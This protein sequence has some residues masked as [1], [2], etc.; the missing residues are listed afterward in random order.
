MIENISLH[1]AVI[2]F[3][4]KSYAQIDV[5]QGIEVFNDT[6]G[7]RIYPVDNKFSISYMDSYTVYRVAE[8]NTLVLNLNTRRSWSIYGPGDQKADMTE[9]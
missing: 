6:K 3:V 9:F 5:P 1:L 8:K 2:F 7:G 4:N